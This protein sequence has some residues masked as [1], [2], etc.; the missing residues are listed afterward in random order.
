VQR[1]GQSAL[2]YV[3]V[4]GDLGAYILRRETLTQNGVEGTTT[5]NA[6]GPIEML[7]PRLS[8]TVTTNVAGAPSP[9]VAADGNT[10]TIWSTSSPQ[11]SG[12]WVQLDF[13]AIR[14][15]AAYEV[16]ARQFT[17]LVV[18]E[19]SA[20]GFDWNPIPPD[21]E[22]TTFGPGTALSPRAQAR[23]LRV[24]LVTD[25]TDGWSLRDIRVWGS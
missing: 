2:S 9:A 18:Y 20:D 4:A 10:S 8:A 14:S 19:V 7:P 5:S 13:G 12:D 16:T 25:G 6:V 17:G 15:L 21:P 1:G 24:R 22:A 23:F 3:T 11:R